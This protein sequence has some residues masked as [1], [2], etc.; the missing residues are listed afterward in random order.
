MGH[1]A[2]G[3]GKTRVLGLNGFFRFLNGQKFLEP[4]KKAKE[5][6]VSGHRWP[7]AA[8]SRRGVA[9]GRAWKQGRALALPGP[10]LVV[11]A[12]RYGAPL[13]LVAAKPRARSVSIRLYQHP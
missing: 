5:T 7:A 12:M 9:A 11:L 2:C 4:P 10:P 1:G 13:P 8:A 6:L 3:G